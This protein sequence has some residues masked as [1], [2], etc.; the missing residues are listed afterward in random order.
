M[1]QQKLL[2]LYPYLKVQGL[3]KPGYVFNG[4][5]MVSKIGM[6]SE[7]YNELDFKEFIPYANYDGLLDLLWPGTWNDGSEVRL[8]IINTDDLI[9]QN[10]EKDVLQL[11][12]VLEYAVNDWDEIKG[13]ESLS[14]YIS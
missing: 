14:V 4:A 6:I 8:H 1:N 11:F 3:E 2:K 9:K 5:N 10:T 13:K 7:I 12:E